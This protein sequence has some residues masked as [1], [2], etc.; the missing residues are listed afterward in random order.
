MSETACLDRFRNSELEHVVSLLARNSQLGGA[1]KSADD[2]VVAAWK[3]LASGWHPNYYVGDIPLVVKTERFS[4][5]KREQLAAKLSLQCYQASQYTSTD[6]ELSHIVVTL[7]TLAR[8]KVRVSNVV[9]VAPAAVACQ[10]AVNALCVEPR[11]H[12]R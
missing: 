6:S 2:L 7:M 3:T 1:E 5:T 8:L 11:P 4:T 10:R 12:R 9:T